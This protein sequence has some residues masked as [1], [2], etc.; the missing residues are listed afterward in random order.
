MHLTSACSPH[1]YTLRTPSTLRACAQAGQDIS[2]RANRA[3]KDTKS[4]ASDEADKVCWVHIG[5]MS[6]IADYVGCMGGRGGQCAHVLVKG[7]WPVPFAAGSGKPSP[8]VHVVQ[9]RA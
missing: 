2:D 7:T 8:A 5:H 9:V 4:A 3:Y 6:G 1:P